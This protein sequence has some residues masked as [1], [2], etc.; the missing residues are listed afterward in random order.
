MIPETDEE[1]MTEAL[2]QAREAR[3]RD[4]VPIGAVIVREGQVIA[5][6]FNQVEMLYD[7]TAHAE[8]IAITQAAAAMKTKWLYDCCLYVTVEPCAM[9]AGALVLARIGRICFG[10]ADPK[11]GACGSVVDIARHRGLN[12]QC[13]VAGGVMAEECG[14]LL[15]AFF[16][17]KRA[18]GRK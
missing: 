12:H 6:A 2:R 9:C 14:G 16:S 13:S 10:A 18:Q 8:M 5:R 7:P 17:G 1:F 11:A 4:E 3:D 15:S